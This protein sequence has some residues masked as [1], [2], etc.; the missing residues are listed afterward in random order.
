M[1]KKRAI[2][3]LLAFV[4][5]CS[6][7]LFSA[8]AETISTQPIDTEALKQELQQNIANVLAQSGG[9]LY[10]PLATG[11]QA[12]YGL[13]Q[14]PSGQMLLH[15][16]NSVTTGST[17]YMGY[18]SASNTLHT[19]VFEEYITGSYIVRPVSQSSLCL[20]VNASTGN[21]SLQPFSWQIEQYW[22][23][24]TYG[25]GVRLLTNS[26]ASAV[27]GKYLDTSSVSTSGTVYG[28]IPYSQLHG[29]S[30]LY[31]YGAVIQKNTTKTLSPPTYSNSATYDFSPWT[32][33]TSSNP[34][35]CTVSSDGVI[36]AWNTGATSVLV[37]NSIMQYTYTCPITIV[38]GYAS[39]NVNTVYELSS[40]TVNDSAS[41]YLSYLESSLSLFENEFYI[42]ASTSTMGSTANLDGNNCADVHSSNM[43]MCSA[44]PCGANAK[45]S[46]I[47]HRSALRLLWADVGNVPSGTYLVR[48]VN[49]VM[50]YYNSSDGRH[51]GVNGL[52]YSYGDDAIVTKTSS[53]VIRTTRH[54]ISHWFGAL[55]ND[56]NHLYSCMMSSS[57]ENGNWCVNCY[58]KIVQAR[59]SRP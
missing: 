24:I 49:H 36:S 41:E 1:I 57:N 52:T 5:I 8:S 31:Q 15:Q 45:C 54:E 35:L 48:Y 28:M 18:F 23:P 30:A 56:C 46:D 53:D 38:D 34:N 10:T 51:Y 43:V 19:W 59:A 47:H 12:S 39:M 26:S 55:D 32:G 42:S 17:P 3:L 4:M 37:T 7:C 29:L 11:D 9:E 44:D 27:S 13:A 14:I 21:V 22:S 2:S 40:Y 33:Y 58:N 20:T 6:T 50:C 25:D 16:G